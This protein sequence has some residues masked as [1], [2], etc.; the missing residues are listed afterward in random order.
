MALTS[1]SRKRKRVGGCA[2]APGGG[3]GFGSVG[4]GGSGRGS[5]ELRHRQPRARALFSRL[6]PHPPALRYGGHQ[7][8][9]G[10]RATPVLLGAGRS[11]QAAAVGGPR[12]GGDGAGG[13]PAGRGVS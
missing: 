3:R 7:Q 8:Q 2:E 4:G 12:V 1:D 5:A 13:A 11:R 10:G 6:L 9:P